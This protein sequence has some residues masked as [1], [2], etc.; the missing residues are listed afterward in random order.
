MANLGAVGGNT[1]FFWGLL[2]R[3]TNAIR[4][5]MSISRVSNSTL[6]G[7]FP[8]TPQEGNFEDV[9]F[10]TLVKAVRWGAMV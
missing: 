7:S 4:T 6:G 2:E 8:F 1:S 3:D 5:E 9:S 10:M